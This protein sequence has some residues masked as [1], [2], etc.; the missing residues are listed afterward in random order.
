MCPISSMTSKIKK[1]QQLHKWGNLF[2]S[3]FKQCKASM[4]NKES[5]KV[6]ILER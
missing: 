3:Y 2:F 1:E 6:Y 4:S 5:E